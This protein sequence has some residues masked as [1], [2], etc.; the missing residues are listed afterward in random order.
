M[1]TT[2]GRQSNGIRKKYSDSH[3]VVPDNELENINLSQYVLTPSIYTHR[4]INKNRIL[5]ITYICDYRNYH[6]KNID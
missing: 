6:Y 2:N 3:Q 5:I 1:F 4:I